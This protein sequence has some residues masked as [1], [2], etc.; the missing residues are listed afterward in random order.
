MIAAILTALGLISCLWLL[1]TMAAGVV[2]L[3]NLLR[4]D[5]AMLNTSEAKIVAKWRQRQP[6][7]ALYRLYAYMYDCIRNP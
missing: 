2:T 3:N 1:A 6:I 5:T 7:R 4:S